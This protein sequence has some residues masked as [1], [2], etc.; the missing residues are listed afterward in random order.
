MPSGIYDRT[1]PPRKITDFDWK[2]IASYYDLGHSSYDCIIKFGIRQ[3]NWK[4]ATKLGLVKPRSFSES[5]KLV[6]RKTWTPERRKKVSASLTKLFDEK[7]WMHP[8]AR[9]AKLHI[10]G[11]TY[12]EKLAKQ[13]LDTA[14]IVYEAQARI[15]RFWIDFLVGKICIEIDG[16]FWHGPTRVQYSANRD[17]QITA[18]GF[19]IFHFPAKE[20]MTNPQTILSVL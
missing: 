16:E 6:A 11:M 8:C 3:H 13:A 4:T 12:P 14:K 10:S 9:N 7:P 15:K 17:A 20:V 18:L 19:K 1:T 5:H 2:A